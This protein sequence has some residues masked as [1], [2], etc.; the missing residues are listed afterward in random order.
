MI[1]YKNCDIKSE[2]QRSLL[3]AEF[4]KLKSIEEERKQSAKIQ[5]KDFCDRPAL[6]GIFVSVAVSWFLQM[7]GCYTITN[8]AS[9]IFGISGTVFGTNVSSIILA[10]VQIIGGLLSTQM[11]DTFGRKTTLSISLVGSILGL[12]SL[13]VY[14]YLRQ[15]G[16]DVSNYTWL[17][18]VSLA[19][20]ILITS[21]G[22]MA[23]S[24]IC[25]IENFPPKVNMHMSNNYRKFEPII[26]KIN[27]FS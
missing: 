23:L 8:Y 7:T 16:Y 3:K 11:G 18:L 13:S 6:K 26:R 17:P 2:R 1:Y 27:V 4:E 15:I 9:F 21:A 24:N 14:L 25:A 12:I 22:I 20:I 5:L 19:L 10:V